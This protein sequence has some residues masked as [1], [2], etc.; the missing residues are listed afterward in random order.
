MSPKN[1]INFERLYKPLDMRKRRANFSSAHLNNRT[2][3]PAAMQPA[4][5]STQSSNLQHITPDQNAESSNLNPSSPM[6]GANKD[7][8]PVKTATGGEQNED[9]S[10]VNQ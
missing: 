2:R 7:V 1:F 8:A 10:T 5:K 3:N 6:P 4:E 9:V